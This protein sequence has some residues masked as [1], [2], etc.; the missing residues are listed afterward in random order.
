MDM[1]NHLVG[2]LISGYMPEESARF[3]VTRTDHL[4]RL[5]YSQQLQE[6]AEQPLTDG[7]T[8]RLNWLVAQLGKQPMNY[9]VF[10]ETVTSKPAITPGDGMGTR[11]LGVV[12]SP[13][14]WDSSTNG[15]HSS[16]FT[17]SSES[18]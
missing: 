17:T 16:P 13:T 8:L 7:E 3:V 6:L 2:Y 14:A 15:R 5:S 9:T 18:L 10:V 12:N 1:S 4:D 11:K